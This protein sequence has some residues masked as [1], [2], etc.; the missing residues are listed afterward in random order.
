MAL[1]LVVVMSNVDIH[2]DDPANRRHRPDISVIFGVAWQRW[3]SFNVR[4]E[5]RRPGLI[6]EVPS[7]A[8]RQSDLNEKLAEYAEFDVEWYLIV[9]QI[10]TTPDGRV[11]LRL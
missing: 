2:W 5:G 3:E 4:Q 9:D 8:T 11:A 10:A 6:V 1:G 7:N